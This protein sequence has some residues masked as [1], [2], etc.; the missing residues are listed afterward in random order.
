MNG[1]RHCVCLDHNEG[2]CSC[3]QKDVSCFPY[4]EGCFVGIFEVTIIFDFGY[5]FFHKQR[6]M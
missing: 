2:D 1:C 4:L 3:K 5:I 6:S